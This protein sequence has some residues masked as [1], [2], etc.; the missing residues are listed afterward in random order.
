MFLICQ[1]I[2]AVLRKAARDMEMG[3]GE[4]EPNPTVMKFGRAAL[5]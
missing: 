5:E 4:R 1:R 2:V 3:I